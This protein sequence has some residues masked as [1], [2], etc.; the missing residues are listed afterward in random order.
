MFWYW[1]YHSFAGWLLRMQLVLLRSFS[2]FVVRIIYKLTS[3]TVRSIVTVQVV[4]T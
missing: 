4:T 2:F 1:F 3:K